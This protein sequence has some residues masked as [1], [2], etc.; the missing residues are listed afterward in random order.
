M[1][2]ALLSTSL[3]VLFLVLSISV[4]SGLAQDVEPVD[5]TLDSSTPTVAFTETPYPTLTEAPTLTPVLIETPSEIPT[6]TETA[7]LTATPV[8]LE[9]PTLS[10]PTPSET[11]PVEITLTPGIDP[12]PS[13]TFD[14]LLSLTPSLTSTLLETAT[15]TATPSPTETPYPPE[16]PMALLFSDNFDSGSLILWTLS[17]GWSLVSS[18]AGQALQ[19]TTDLPVTFVHNTLYEAAVQARFQYTTGMIRLALRESKEGSYEVYLTPDGQVSLNRNGLPIATGLVKPL[20]P[21]QWRTI[22]LSAVG[23]YLRVSIDDQ[24]IIVVPEPSPLPPGTIAF[25]GLAA[26]PFLVDDVM[27]WTPDEVE[28]R[29]Q[30]VGATQP[31]AE[32]PTLDTKPTF[33]YVA[34]DTFEVSGGLW[35]TQP[36]MLES[37]A[38]GKG[39]VLS[40]ENP[41]VSYGQ[42]YLKNFQFGLDV[43]LNSSTF[44][45]GFNQSGA[46]IYFLEWN[47]DGLFSLYRNS[48]LIAESKVGSLIA[49]TSYRVE[50]QQIEGQISISFDGKPVIQ[51][52]DPTPLPP[53]MIILRSMDGVVD[54]ISLQANIK[55]PVSPFDNLPTSSP[56]PKVQSLSVLPAASRIVYTAIDYNTRG[57]PSRIM[58]VNADGTNQVTLTTGQYTYAKLPAWSPDGQKVAFIMNQDGGD[59]IYV[60]DLNTMNPPV[61]LTDLSSGIYSLSWSVPDPSGKQW[62]LFTRPTTHMGVAVR[63]ATR[64]DV[65]S[66]MQS[67]NCQGDMLEPAISG[68]PSDYSPDWAPN[69]ASRF[70]YVEPG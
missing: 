10:E 65:A 12:E 43:T 48:I 6:L 23:D 25:N 53:G 13:L 11:P 29:S 50:I 49:G 36:D 28:G 39:L 33:E 32:T 37:R 68:S 55:K 14:G 60:I 57:S 8:P 66:C 19:S 63:R 15:E 31:A 38:T 54:N 22:R 5:P 34:T 16:P 44:G 7:T 41:L 30:F 24:E 26:S 42:G 56:S 3:L 62:L 51:V 20:E 35:D 47:L 18:E 61:K 9:T 69:S 45:I 4:E 52:N 1:G 58:M 21:G 17:E 64:L 40:H 46:G 59:Q 27:V 67:G 70:L 2:R